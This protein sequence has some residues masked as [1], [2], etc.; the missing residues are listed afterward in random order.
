M[1]V[2]AVISQL[3]GYTRLSAEKPGYSK[4]RKPGYS[5]CR[6]VPCPVDSTRWPKCRTKTCPVPKTPFRQT[7]QI[8]ICLV[9]F[10]FSPKVWNYYGKR[11]QMSRWQDCRGTDHR[12]KCLTA[13]QI[14]HGFQ[15]SEPVLHCK[16]ESCTALC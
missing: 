9:P 8:L 15:A 7:A 4:R 1:S 16:T 5:K 3:G 14:V 12:A 10:D 13:S 11:L 6:C 2:N